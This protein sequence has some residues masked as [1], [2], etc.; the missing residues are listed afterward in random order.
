MPNIL[1]II[2]FIWLEYKDI[3]KFLDAKFYLYLCANSF[4]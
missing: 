2:M 3:K 4:L 1:F